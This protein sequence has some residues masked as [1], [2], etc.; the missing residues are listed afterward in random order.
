MSLH[1][2]TV[3]GVVTLVTWGY[4]V[5]GRGRF[6]SVRLRNPAPL[7]TRP[8][9]AAI[10]PARNEAEVVGRAVKSLL[11]QAS[12]DLHMYLV[13]DNSSDGTAEVA[14]SVGRQE[15]LT[16]IQGKPLPAGWT[17]KVWAMQQGLKAALP[18]KPD[19]LLFTDSDIE[20]EPGNIANLARIAKEDSLDLASFMVRL[21]C[22]TV[23]EKLLIPAFVFFFFKLY[24]PRWIADPANATA[25]AAGGCILI[26]PEALV[27]AGGLEQIKGEI[28]DDC[29]LAR[30]VKRSGGKIWLGLSDNAQSIRPYPTFASIGRMIS[31]TAF[32]QLDHSVLLLFIAF[33]GLLFTYI[34]PLAVMVSSIPAAMLAGGIAFTL[35]MIAYLPM[36]RFYRLNPLWALT[37]P[38][39]A[40]FYLAATMNSAV[41]YWL[42]RGGQWKGRAQDQASAGA[43]HAR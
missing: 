11:Q 41:E 17:G 26:R 35:M 9:I 25:G 13:D 37:L 1:A 32:N 7:R 22:E 23:P 29:S 21:H 24:P 6:W 20:H 8:R 16:V 5:F 36:V 18:G 12:V 43:T 19:F 31:R 40:M 30:A 15:R 2:P 27:R 38:I 39:A 42:G 33:L 3:V 28:I 34:A 4:L 10:V 14:R